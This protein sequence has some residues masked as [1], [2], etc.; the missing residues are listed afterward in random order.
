M[1]AKG[2]TL[3]EAKHP[4][5]FLISEDSDGAGFLS[6]DQV[7]IAPNNACVV[8]Q[9]LAKQAIVANV[10]ETVATG[11]NTGNGTLTL[12]NPAVDTT[13]RGGNHKITF[14]DATHF[15]VEGVDGS[16]IG[17]GT[18][19]TAFT[20]V[21]KFTISAGGTP[22]VAGDSFSI[23][24]DVSEPEDTLYIPWVP[25]LRA[26]AICGYPVRLDAVNVQ[27]VTVI[28]G[29]SVIRLSDVTFGGSPTQDQ[30]DQAKR[31][32]GARLIKFR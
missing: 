13:V 3:T 29:H 22:F 16:A 24:V 19:G 25:G 8:G 1:T 18:V 6:R 17:E 4:L 2:I 30:I 20:K 12:A 31:E 10:T 28:N 27:K 9:I 15:L 11:T 5:C 21:L 14:T 7:N 32:L 23:N 26:E